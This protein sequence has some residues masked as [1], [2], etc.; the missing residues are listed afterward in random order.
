MT[1]PK[2]PYANKLAYTLTTWR[3][4]VIWCACEGGGWREC[5]AQ[6]YGV[7]G[8]H[9]TVVENEGYAYDTL[10]HIPTGKALMCGATGEERE[11]LVALAERLTA[12]GDWNTR[13]VGKLKRLREAM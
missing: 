10:T 11:Q 8:L 1:T 6:V 7:F 12:L 13:S 3:E 2:H 9:H 4:C 5:V